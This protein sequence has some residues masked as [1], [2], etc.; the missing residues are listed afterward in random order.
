MGETRT[1]LAQRE[2][3]LRRVA[4][5]LSSLPA[6]TASRILS[7]VDPQS[8]NLVH[9]AVAVLSNVPAEERNS[10]LSSFAED[11]RVSRRSTIDSTPPAIDTSGVQDE[12]VLGESN[13]Q[14]SAAIT[15][16]VP[17][18]GSA[19]KGH[20]AAN[21]KVAH[22]A[23][24][25]DVDKDE[26]T[27]LLSGERPQTIAVVL[28]SIS[29]KQAADVL[30][31]L[32][33]DLQS[34]TLNRIGRLEEVADATAAAV[35]DHL[36]SRYE[37]LT[38]KPNS[39]GSDALKAIMSELPQLARAKEQPAPQLETQPVTQSPIQPSSLKIA[40]GTWPADAAAFQSAP[41]KPVEPEPA[42]FQ[43][44][45]FQPAQIQPV[46]PEPAQFEPAQFQPAE[47]ITAPSVSA[48]QESTEA[49]THYLVD[50]SPKVLVA[51]LGRVGTRDALLTLCGLPN[52]TA[53]AAIALLPRAKA[54]AARQG[55]TQL[56][57]LRL[58]DIDKAKL[59][60]AKA[61]KKASS[62][63]APQGVAH[64]ASLPSR[65]AA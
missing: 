32:D 59:A 56:G 62:R 27:E 10:A 4:L 34:Q 7:Q 6:P 16:F 51:S 65:V 55:M 11:L 13:T 57:S 28:A 54:K 14:D 37:A 30:P 39:G 60:V 25:R 48:P 52:E 49:V 35:A 20:D 29:P 33:A 45:Q 50:L 61:A 15:P 2:T 38:A 63:S 12:I 18:F 46:Q 5:V 42:Q 3:M 44:A 43:P 24:L 17:Q 41:I 23:F 8:R 40:A 58:S 31:R 21:E 36:R 9:Q 26:L 64:G 19:L 53:E 1:T 22:F 47:S